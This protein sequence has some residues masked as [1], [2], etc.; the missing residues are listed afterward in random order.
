MGSLSYADD[1]TLLSPSSY[2]LNRVLE[3]CA[4][5]ADNFDTIF[6][7][8]KTLCIKFDE[9]LNNKK[10]VKLNDKTIKWV[11]HINLSGNL[12]FRNFSFR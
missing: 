1:I 9:S 7:G 8:K 12:L 3:I 4:K 5:C 2:G 6:N 10:C 11:D